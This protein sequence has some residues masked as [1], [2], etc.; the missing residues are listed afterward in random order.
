[1]ARWT[2]TSFGQVDCPRLGEQHDICS[3]CRAQFYRQ[4]DLSIY[5]SDEISAQQQIVASNHR[6]KYHT[7]VEW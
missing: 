6:K 5:F 1:M 2:T 7:L 3:T 4:N